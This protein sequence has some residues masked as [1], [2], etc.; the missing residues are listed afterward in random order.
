MKA[1]FLSLAMVCVV[2]SV[3]SNAQTNKNNTI[4]KGYYSIGNNAGKLSGGTALKQTHT[5]GISSGQKGYYTI[6]SRRVKVLHA[7]KIDVT[8]SPAPVKKGYYSI[9][10][11]EKK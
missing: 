7:Y 9:G 3:Y 6:P 1:R 11:N 4:S 8:A 10:R 5:I 2:L